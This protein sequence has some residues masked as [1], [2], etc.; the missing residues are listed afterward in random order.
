L[1][2]CPISPS[3]PHTHDVLPRCHL[4]FSEA[5]LIGKIGVNK[6]DKWQRRLEVVATC[7][8]GL[9]RGSGLP[10]NPV[11]RPVALPMTLARGWTNEREPALALGLWPLGM[12]FRLLAC[13]T[14]TSVPSAK[15]LGFSRTTF[16]FLT[17]PRIVM[18]R[19][20]AFWCRGIFRS[21]NTCSGSHSQ[22]LGTRA[23][24]L[25]PL[26]ALGSDVLNRG[27]FQ[28]GAATSR[29]R[30]AQEIHKQVTFSMR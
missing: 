2:D 5:Q 1:R 11:H 4:T 19:L 21:K 23:R 18:V 20:R 30:H 10:N 9:G 12:G 17:L 6:K 27:G 24:I 16:P 7:L 14:S 8:F 3:P 13:R 22:S 25:C 26:I 15:A 28:A 29:L